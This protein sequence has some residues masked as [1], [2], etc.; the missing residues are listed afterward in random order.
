MQKKDVI[1]KIYK[2]AI[3]FSLIMLLLFLMLIPISYSLSIG[4]AFGVSASLIS[5]SIGILLIKKFFKRKRSRILGFWMGWLRFYISMGVHAGIFIVV[6]A[7]NS[8]MNSNSFASGGLSDMISPINIFTYIG[9]VSVIFISTI[10]AY[11]YLR[12]DNDDGK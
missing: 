2:I 6:I 12:K 9:G 3:I 10:I 7:L 5:Y 11:F 4:W 1:Y 8:F